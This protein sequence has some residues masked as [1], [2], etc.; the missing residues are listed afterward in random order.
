MP[1]R[2]WVMRS[3]TETM[4]RARRWF[5]SSTSN[6]YTSFATTARASRR[7]MR[8]YRTM[9]SRAR[10]SMLRIAS[11]EIHPLDGHAACSSRAFVWAALI[12]GAV[13]GAVM[14]VLYISSGW[15][16]MR[17]GLVEN[18]INKIKKMVHA[19]VVARMLWMVLA[20]RVRRMAAVSSSASSWMAE[21]GSRQATRYAAWCVRLCWTR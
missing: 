16:K 18:E 13:V 21:M 20:V 17:V 1:V 7:E 4:T 3:C 15:E 19:P 2:R 6:M 9:Y 5:V 14:M 8:L 12:D 11:S 10:V